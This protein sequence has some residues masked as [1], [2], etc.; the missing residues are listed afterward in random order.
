VVAFHY[1]RK[2]IQE[3]AAVDGLACRYRDFIDNGK[4]E[5]E[6]VNSIISLAE[7]KGYKDIFETD[8]LRAG[9][10]V[11]Y[12][13]M[14]K[15]IALLH[16]GSSS[17]E[18]GMNILGAHIDSPR[19]DIKQR[20]I[21]E[22]DGLVY[23]DTHYYGGIKK[24]QW[25]TLPL[26]IHGVLVKKDGTVLHL[27]IG[28]DP[29]EPALS[30]SDILPHLSKE[31]DKL[32]V[33]EAIKGEDLDLL[34]G[35]AKEK[36]K[37]KDELLALFKEKYGIDE[38]DFLSSELEVVPAGKARIQGLDGSMI[39]A[40]GQDDR[41]CAFASM[42]AI[43][44]SDIQERTGLCLLMD[45]E[46]IGSVGATG[47]TSDFL[48]NVISEVLARTDGF[49]GLRLARCLRNSQM[50]S[51]DVSVAYDPLNPSLFDKKNTAALGGGVTFNK[52]TGVR[53]KFSSNDANPEFIAKIRRLMDDNGIKFQFCE[54]GKVDQGGGGTIAAYAARYNMQVL[55]CG[56]AVLSMHAPW[57]TIATEDL[58]SARDCYK[59]FL[60]LA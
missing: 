45:K 42:E 47:M 43:L 53:G 3:V 40:Y 54:L 14:N 60:T 12:S 9:D 5:R 10:K 19:L 44:E 7:A 41:C 59:A 46:E 2:K 27:T 35:L 13:L 1:W 33:A 39:L 23:L 21:Y 31:Q 20:P 56:I 24:Y 25:V 30:I 57:E 52:Y 15:S 18:A 28:E 58:H 55:D 49:D 32:S 8:R 51:S 29:D 6:C 16:I 11:Y 4:T 17:L 36:E 34:A 38:D 37:G 22:K 26:A 50:L 48:V